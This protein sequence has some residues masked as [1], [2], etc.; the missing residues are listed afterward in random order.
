[1]HLLLTKNNYLTIYFIYTMHNKNPFSKTPE[2]MRANAERKQLNREK[3]KFNYIKLIIYVFFANTIE[4][5][6]L[7]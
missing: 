7:A 3:Y 4:I 1:M 6:N 2:K 5:I